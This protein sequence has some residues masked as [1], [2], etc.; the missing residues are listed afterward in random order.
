MPLIR[1]SHAASF[2]QADK[3]KIMQDVTAAYASASGCD[4]T[5]VWI[6]LEEVEKSDWATG[7][8]SIASR[9]AS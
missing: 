6:I 8:A 5:K 2:G 3:E 4:P 1:V 9:T 7:G